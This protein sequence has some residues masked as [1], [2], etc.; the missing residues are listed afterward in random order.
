MLK[1]IKKQRTLN[2][3]SEVKF[4]A[5][6]LRTKYKKCVSNCKH[7]ALTMK[8]AS[9]IKRFQENRGFGAW[10]NVLLPL[11]KSRDSH[12]S[13]QDIEPVSMKQPID[14]EKLINSDVSDDQENM[15]D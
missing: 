5:K 4:T 3:G 12:Q 11:A 7:A 9:E 10:C 15:K 1:F 14:T 6:Q 8:S 2:R 13:D